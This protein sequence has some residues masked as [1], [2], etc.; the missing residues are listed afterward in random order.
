MSETTMELH[1]DWFFPSLFAN[2]LLEIRRLSS[3]SVRFAAF[4]WQSSNAQTVD[5]RS[6]WSQTHWHNHLASPAY[7]FYVIYCEHEPAGC[8]EIKRATRLML[9]KG[10]VAE[11]VSIGLLPEFKG[12]GLGSDLLTRIVEKTLATGAARVRINAAANIDKTARR[13]LQNQGFRVI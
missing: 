8:A 12:E 10:G 3:A 2:D 1:K 6:M 13:L 7:E 5:D 4:L 9:N 11:I